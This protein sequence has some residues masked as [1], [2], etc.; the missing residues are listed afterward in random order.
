MKKFIFT[1]LLLFGM[2][3]FSP[4]FASTQDS[5]TVVVASAANCDV[6]SLNIPVF[7]I[8][9]VEVSTSLL[10]TIH[11]GDIEAMTVVKDPEITKL[12]APRRGG[13]VIITTKSKK[14]LKPI[15]ENWNGDKQKRR[16]T[17]H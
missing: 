16:E 8:D 3:L 10:E 1:V 5:S 6:D 9:G 13:V 11:P 4:T 15:L 17:K 2:N 14:F 12:F 7:L